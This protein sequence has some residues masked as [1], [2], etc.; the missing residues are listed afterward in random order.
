MRVKKEERSE[1]GEPAVRRWKKTG[2]GISLE[3][4]L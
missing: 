2:P 4:R 3:W 1:L